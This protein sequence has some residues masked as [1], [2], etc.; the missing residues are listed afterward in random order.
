ML[1]EVPIAPLDRLELAA[2]DGDQ[3]I[4]EQVQAPAQDH[5]LPA[6]PPDRLTVVA[7]KVRNRLEVWA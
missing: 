3:R 7:A 6:H 5:K 4:A 2:I 1:R